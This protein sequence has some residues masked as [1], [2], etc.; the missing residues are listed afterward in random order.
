MKFI[1]AFAMAALMSL[2]PLTWVNAQSPTPATSPTA[3][4]QSKKHGKW[5]FD[6]LKVLAFMTRRLNLTQEQQDK[7]LPILQQEA[8]ALNSSREQ[9]HAILTPDQLRLLHRGHRDWNHRG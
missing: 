4:Q 2:A 1:T 9:I 7:I 5:G 3:S 8:N 6:P